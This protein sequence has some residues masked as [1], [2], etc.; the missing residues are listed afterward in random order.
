MAPRPP[1]KEAFAIW[2][3]VQQPSENEEFCTRRRKN[4]VCWAVWRQSMLTSQLRCTYWLCMSAIPSSKS[5]RGGEGGP[6]TVC[7]C[8]TFACLQCAEYHDHGVDD[9]AY[10]VLIRTERV[11]CNVGSKLIS[12]NFPRPPRTRRHPHCPNTMKKVAT[13]KNQHL[14]HASNK[15]GNEPLNPATA[16]LV[17]VVTV[18]VT[19]SSD[20]GCHNLKIVICRYV[21]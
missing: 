19:V 18:L 21:I 13:L 6:P 8:A 5:E 10:K 1:S 12:C 15:Q 11:C 16:L 20:W 3:T 7:R 2:V 17:I 9:D 4:G 14:L